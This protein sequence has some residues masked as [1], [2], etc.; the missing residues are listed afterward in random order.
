M[1]TPGKVGDLG[2]SGDNCETRGDP[3][4]TQERERERGMGR[5]R[6]RGAH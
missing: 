4:K 3:G 1:G 2:E 5:W 6:A